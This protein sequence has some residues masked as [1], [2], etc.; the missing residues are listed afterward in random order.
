MSIIDTVRRV[1]PGARPEYLDAIAQG[2]ALYASYDIT[3]PL[4]VAHFHAQVMHETGGLK[5]VRESGQYSAAR[6]S[7]IFGV[8]RH[9]AA[10]TP[11]EARALAFNGP[12]LFER[13]YGRGNPRKAAELGN[14]QPGDGWTFRGNGLM[15]TTGRG[16]HRRLGAAVGL[17]NL[18]EVNPEVVTSAQYALLPALAEWRESR[19]N[20][21][22]DRNDLLSITRAINGGTNGLDDRE[23][24][25]ERM[26][27]AVDP[28]GSPSWQ[29]G[30]QDQSTKALQQA[31][32]SLGLGPLVEDGKL[33]P[34][35][36]AA[37]IKFQAAN[38][39][40]ADGIAGPLTLAA[41][42]LRLNIKR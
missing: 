21:M 31:L 15:Q 16:A 41:I 12:A 20:E 3:T 35:T 4:R 19:C 34:A 40:R 28:T 24:W 13:V 32:N 18:F 22:A 39:L 33:G 1:C 23:E 38:G 42:E 2:A 5:I 36:K 30:R 29:A 10:V 6:I 7:E 26:W 27:A 37:V 8:G 9:S 14:S 17:G 25:F 11:A